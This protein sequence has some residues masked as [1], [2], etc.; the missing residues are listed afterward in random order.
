MFYTF[1]RE[2]LLYR[3]FSSE[4]LRSNLQII[5][6]GHCKLKAPK[7]A[8]IL[9]WNPHACGFWLDVSFFSHVKKNIVRNSDWTYRFFFPP[10]EKHRSLLWMARTHLR[11]KI[12]VIAFQWVWIIIFQPMTDSILYSIPIAEFFQSKLNSQL[13]DDSSTSFF[14]KQIPNLLWKKLKCKN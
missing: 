6:R 2:R 11:M 4:C 10:C 7:K 14:P 8:G 12:Y 9:A 3:V 1:L 13:L 5:K